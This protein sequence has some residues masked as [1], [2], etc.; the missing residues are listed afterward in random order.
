MIVLRPLLTVRAAAR[1]LRSP[2]GRSWCHPQPFWHVP[3]LHARSRVSLQDEGGGR[4]VDVMEDGT[5]GEDDTASVGPRKGRGTTTTTAR[6]TRRAQV[7]ATHSSPATNSGGS[8]AQMTDVLPPKLRA[9]WA[10]SK[11]N[12]QPTQPAARSTPTREGTKVHLSNLSVP[13][14]VYAQILI[15]CVVSSK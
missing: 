2:P 15:V 5:A 9:K 8:G 10:S 3:Y 14:L 4:D 7:E 6:S 1:P 12:M 11:H 13:G